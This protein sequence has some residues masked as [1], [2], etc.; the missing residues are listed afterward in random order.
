MENVTEV[1][2]CPTKAG[3]GF[4]ICVDGLWLYASKGAVQD[5]VNKGHNCVFHT[6]DAQSDDVSRE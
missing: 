2:L 3:R 6:I 1:T 4:K 5:V